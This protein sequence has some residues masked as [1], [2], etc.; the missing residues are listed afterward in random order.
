M[1]QAPCK[2]QQ[3]CHR[4]LESTCSV[5]ETRVL[6]PPVLLGWATSCLPVDGCRSRLSVHL[7]R[8]PAGEHFLPGKCFYQHLLGEPDVSLDQMG[9]TAIL[10]HLLLVA[11]KTSEGI[12]HEYT[13]VFSARPGKVLQCSGY[14]RTFPSFRSDIINPSSGFWV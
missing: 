12:R 13:A 14:F 7:L 10:Q 11:R 8:F 1:S 6:T 2:R 5:M 4:E 9:W 3:R